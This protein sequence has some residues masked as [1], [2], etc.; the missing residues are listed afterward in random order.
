METP[1]GHDMQSWRRLAD[2]G[3][4]G[5][6][7]PERHGGR[8]KGW[9]E[10]YQFMEQAGAA[11]LCA[12]YLSTVA[13][14]AT[15]I[16]ECSD[17]SVRQRYLPEIAGGRLLATVAIAEDSGRWDESGLRLAAT[18][19]PAADSP[20]GA[21]WALDGHKSY[22]TDG[23]TAEVLVVAA[24]TGSG[25]S[26]MFLVDGDAP[27]L[28]RRRLVTVDQTRK[29]AHLEL[30]AVPARRLP[31]VTFDRVIDLAVLALSAEC[32]GGAQRCLDLS[33]AHAS[34][35]MQ[36]GQPIGSF[37]AVA[38]RC[39]EMMVDIES[40]RSAVDHAARVADATRSGAQGNDLSLAASVAKVASS[41]A[42]SRAA[43]GAI[44]I[45]GGLGFTWDCDVQ[46]YFK[47]AKSSALLLGDARFHRERL[48]CR[49]G[50]PGGRPIETEMPTTNLGSP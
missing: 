9:V 22:V 31:G 12:P 11:L 50:W 13:M 47:R 14:A 41:D 29:Q 38:H 7:L 39:A 23:E 34:T 5:L 44:Q 20:D 6:H 27:G 40:A 35:R 17:E 26:G 15:A 36:F 19:T 2:S 37:Q 45:H 21:G 32:V 42:Y 43:A 28:R 48:A 49:L 3:L 8:G 1:D 4:L 30:A 16:N 25:R 24:R 33:V 18:D 46:L 10:L